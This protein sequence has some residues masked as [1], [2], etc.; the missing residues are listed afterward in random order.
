MGCVVNVQVYVVSKLFVQFQDE[1]QKIGSGWRV[2]ELLSVGYKYAHVYYPPL[3]TTVK[4][5]KSIWAEISKNAR[6][7]T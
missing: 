6:E 1:C 7:L 5:K 2:V 3:G 4:I